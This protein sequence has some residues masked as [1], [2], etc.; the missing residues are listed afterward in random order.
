VEALVSVLRSLTT[1]VLPSALGASVFARVVIRYLL[2][3]HRGYIN[4]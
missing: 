4:Q 3:S 2:S 1:S